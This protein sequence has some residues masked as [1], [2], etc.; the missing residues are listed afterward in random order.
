MNSSCILFSIDYICS[1]LWS[2]NEFIKNIN[3]H[4]NEQSILIGKKFQKIQ[5]TFHEVEDMLKL[6]STVQQKSRSS[7]SSTRRIKS[8]TPAF[9]NEAMLTFVQYYYDKMNYTIEKIIQ[10]SLIQFIDL[11][12][13][14]QM[15]Y[16]FDQTK[17]LRLVFEG[18]NLDEQLN[19]IDQHR[20]R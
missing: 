20:I 17:L 8:T 11:A 1:K 9:T 5:Q 12:S 7:T 2:P 18:Q 16:L 3:L 10:R 13:I 15:K 19:N 6:N 4:L 14:N